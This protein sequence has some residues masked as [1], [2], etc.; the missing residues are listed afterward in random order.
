MRFNPPPGWPVPGRDW[1]MEYIGLPVTPHRRPDGAPASDPE[2]G[3]VDSART[4]VDQVDGSE[5][6]VLSGADAR[7]RRC[8][9]AC[10]ASALVAGSDG[11]LIVVVGA[12]VAGLGLLV[13]SVRWAQ[14]RKARWARYAKSTSDIRNSGMAKEGDV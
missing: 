5:M 12:M 7:V 2:G 9:V 11:F 8:L 6:V 10:I 1:V 14:F 13:T 4:A 3:V